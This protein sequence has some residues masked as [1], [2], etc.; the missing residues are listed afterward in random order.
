MVPEEV[1]LSRDEA[2]REARN[3][4]ILAMV[5]GFN[6]AMSATWYFVQSAPK[7]P[8]P[9][10]SSWLQMGAGGESSTVEVTQT[11]PRGPARSQL[12]RLPNFTLTDTHGKDVTIY[13]E[14]V[15][16]AV[17]TE[18]L[19]G[20]PDCQ[21]AFQLFP[22]L[23]KEIRAAGQRCVNVAYMGNPRVIEQT[24]RD[25]DFAGPVW[26]DKGSQLQRH[27]GIGSFTM[28]LLAP[29][30][31]ILHQGSPAAIQ[32]FLAAHLK[33]RGSGTLEEKQ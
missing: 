14:G 21:P 27:F 23:A 5:I 31:T 16:P 10:K 17:V 18:F 7:V 2:Q 13:R 33:A 6:M 3:W 4:R 24:F 26:I 22:A 15:A 9:E 30:G 29:D 12:G 8:P 32:P 28:W 11:L 20:C 25:K 1:D 19:I